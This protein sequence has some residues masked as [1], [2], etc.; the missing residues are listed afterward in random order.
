ML[1]TPG[2]LIKVKLNPYKDLLFIGVY[3][4]LDETYKGTLVFLQAGLYKNNI[5]KCYINLEDIHIKYDLE[6]VNEIG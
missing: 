6:L 1:L 5:R 2:N 3:I 4:G